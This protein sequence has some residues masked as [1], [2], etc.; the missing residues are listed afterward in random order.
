M[1]DGGNILVTTTTTTLRSAM[2]HRFGV[3]SPGRYVVLGVRDFGSGMSVDVYEHLFEPFFTTK[4]QGKGTGL[5][6]A[7]VHGIVIQS[8]GQILVESEEEEGTEFSVYLPAFSGAAPPERRLTPSSGSPLA[9][10]AV[11]TVLVV[12]DDDAV[13]DVAVR[14]LAR[15]GFRV[16]AATEGEA[17]LAL[18]AKQDA[19]E[20]I[21]VLTDVLMPGMSGVRLAERVATEYPATRI[22]FMSGFSTDELARSG[23]GSPMRT[24]LNKPFSLPELVG[25]VES[26]FAATAETE[27]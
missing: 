11:R 16:I 23:L 17:A 21:L 18:L 3:L 24:L 2:Q 10:S 9:A 22:A 5:G 27:G 14:A 25:F 26:A 8:G 12:D 20:S 1:P 7:T 15:A 4:S 6:L 13:R 19:D